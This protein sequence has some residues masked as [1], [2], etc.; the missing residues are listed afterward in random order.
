QVHQAA[1]PHKTAPAGV[2]DN[3]IPKHD[4]QRAVFFWVPA[5]ESSPGLIGPDAAKNCAC[6]AEESGEADD[7]VNHFGKA[8]VQVWSALLSGGTGGRRAG[9]SAPYLLGSRLE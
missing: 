4:D 7:S 2:Q 6:E 8:R 9:D 1:F 3:D 5:P